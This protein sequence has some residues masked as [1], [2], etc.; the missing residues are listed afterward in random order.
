M[1]PAN[2][3]VGIEF[4]IGSRM[5]DINPPL[6]LSAAV[7]ANAGAGIGSRTN[8]LRATANAMPAGYG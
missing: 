2:G 7:A 4:R 6:E 8:A 5:D 1:V 3:S